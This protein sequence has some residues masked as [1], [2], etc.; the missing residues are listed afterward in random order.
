MAEVATTA[1]EFVSASGETDGR[2]EQFTKRALRA[3]LNAIPRGNQLSEESWNRRHTAI[4]VLL[5][6]HA[7]A[8]PWLGILN[9]HGV[10]HSFLEAGAVSIFAVGATVRTLSKFTRAV[11]AT[12]GLMSASAILTHFFHGLIE[13]HFHFFVVVAVIT[14]YQSW[15]PFVSA[16]GYVLVHHGVAGALA[17]GSV[18]NHPS[19][20]EHPWRWAA[21][22][23]LFIAGESI[24]CLTAWRLN[25]TALESE[26]S[27]RISSERAN[28]DLAEAQQLARIG[29]WEWEINTGNVWW[30]DELYRICGVDPSVAPSV[31]TFMGLVHPDDRAEVE[32]LLGQVEEGADELG[33]DCR[34]VRADGEVRAVNAMGSIS[35]D[36]SGRRMVG[37]CQDITERKQLEDDIQYRAFHDTLT[38]LANRS[39]FYDRVEHGLVR[40]RK[41]GTLSVMFVDL[42]DFRSIND[43]LGHGAGDELL[44]AVA[45]LLE[46][47]VRAADTIA[48]FGGDEFGIL[49]DDGEPGSAV[50]VAE[51]I[52]AALQSPLEL[53]A[54]EISVQ[55]SIGI[56]HNQKGMTADDLMRDA[57]IALY[58]AKAAEKGGFEVCTAE[59]RT[60]VF[61]RLELA[62]ALKEAVENEEFVLHYQPL[63]DLESNEIAGFEALVRWEHPRLGVVPPNDFI[64]MAE[65]SGAIVPLGAWVLREAMRKTR[66]LQDIT[67][68]RLRMGINISARQLHD[69]DV[70]EIV[71]EMLEETGIDPADIVLEIT[72]TVLMSKKDSITRV[73]NDLRELGVKI[74]IDDF[75]TGYSSL[76]YLHQFPLDILKIDRTFVNA[77]VEGVEEAAVATAIATMANALNL[78]VVAEGIE[79]QAQLDKMRSL[80]CHSAQGYFFSKPQPMGALLEWLED[81]MGQEVR[82]AEQQLEK[83][84]AAS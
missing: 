72:E 6:A 68:R 56:A 61:K 43:R 73:L 46:S 48:R 10:L 27:A 55:A 76:S 24:A 25:E 19:A 42:D 4:V 31:D 20:I 74:A 5:W 79:T 36:E 26:R 2:K 67:G 69:S 22:H 17:P 71:Q 8:V 15:L 1:E 81:R 32:A 33:I 37:T 47:A 18:Y 63:I 70:V 9:G 23:A 3:V 12:F 80:K 62:N 41:E 64:P 60:S 38:G 35:S 29:S 39:L 50:K 53:E 30:S 83:S 51:R 28:K 16:I 52:H 21:V 78:V 34:L 66:L 75:G 40:R 11:L 49:V 54:G 84:P 14:L 65:K 13:M 44:V 7:L 59:M 57:D 45:R 58:A 82:E 77:S